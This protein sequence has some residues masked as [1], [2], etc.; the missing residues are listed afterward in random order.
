[1]NFDE[2]LIDPKA[3]VEEC[4]LAIL[5]AL[6]PT[7]E[8]EKELIAKYK[9]MGIRSGVTMISGFE[10]CIS[11]CDLCVANHDF[12]VSHFAVKLFAVAGGL[13]PFTVMTGLRA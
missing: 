8:M 2:F 5:L 4:R 1:M 10:F 9:E 11:N 12:S 13:S 3:G 6:T 7:A